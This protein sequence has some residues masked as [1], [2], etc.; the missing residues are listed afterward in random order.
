[1]TTAITLA[2]IDYDGWYPDGEFM[3]TDTW[4]SFADL[5]ANSPYEHHGRLLNG[6][7]FE[8]ALTIPASYTTLVPPLDA[9]LRAATNAI[10]TGVALPNINDG[11]VGAAPDL[12]AIERGG[13]VPTYGVRP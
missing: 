1:M 7:P 5:Q 2:D 4:T 11:W 9:R 12:G 10:D 13:T 6:L 8:T 3:F